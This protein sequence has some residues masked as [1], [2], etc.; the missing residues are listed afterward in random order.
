MIGQ[1]YCEV[2]L[3]FADAGKLPDVSTGI[4]ESTSND[5]LQKDEVSS[6]TGEEKLP[7]PP[8]GRCHFWLARKRRFC[9]LLVIANEKFCVEHLATT[10]VRLALYMYF[11]QLLVIKFLL[12]CV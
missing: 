8:E 5:C 2:H 10:E 12:Y 7:A 4:V 6:C 3:K 1:A 9:K 11:F